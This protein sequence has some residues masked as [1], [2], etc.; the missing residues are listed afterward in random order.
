MGGA[1]PQPVIVTA[2]LFDLH[3]DEVQ[4]CDLPLRQFGRPLSCFGPC[5]TLSIFEDHRP[6]L[7]VLQQ[8][9]AGQV[10]VVDG[11]GA[12]RVGVLGDRLAAIALENG[13]RGVVINGAIRDSRGID[14]L[15]I[16]VHALGTTARRGNRE[17][18]GRTGLPLR[19]GG[20]TFTPGDWVYADADCVITAPRELPLPD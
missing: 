8:P 18:E 3:P 19:F 7:R 16:G 5:E 11:A 10:L 12:L 6:V 20:V 1:A 4:V 14:A 13:W 9:G 15:E 2:D 17:T